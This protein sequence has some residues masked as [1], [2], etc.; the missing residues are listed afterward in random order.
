[1]NVDEHLRR[2]AG[3]ARGDSPPKVDVADR[4]V[5][6]LAAREPAQPERTWMW[7]A[8]LSAAAA[9]AVAVMAIP[10]YEMWNDPFREVVETISWVIQ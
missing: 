1:M 10:F 9:A 4:V 3:L 6:A 5:R 8:G 2:L 7:M